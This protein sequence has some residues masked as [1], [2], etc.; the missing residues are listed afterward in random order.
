MLTDLRSVNA[1]SRDFRGITSNT[2]FAKLLLTVSTRE[3]LPRF[4]SRPL[5]PRH[6]A[7][8]LVQ[9]YFDNIFVQMPFFTETSFWTSVD[10]VYQNGGRFAK[11]FDHW[12]VRMVLAIA[13]ASLSH[14]RGSKNYQ[15]AMSLASA[16]LDYS[17]DVLH[18]GSIAGIQAILLLAQYSLVDPEHFRSWYLVGM[19][20]RV[21]VDLGLHQDPPAEV[22]T[23]EDR[24]DLRRR[25][26]Y[27]IYSLDRLV[28]APLFPGLVTG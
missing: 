27:C 10:L 4:S 3:P 26:F 15:R 7:T 24:L 5:P 14:Q 17:E 9:F 18:P 23:D 20:A 25:V 11:P 2:S 13:S 12:I 22:V 8:P 16:A 1:T 19:A 6:E 21:M 28:L